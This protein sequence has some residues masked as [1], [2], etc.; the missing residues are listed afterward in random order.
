MTAQND[1]TPFANADGANALTVSAY[2]G[3][4]AIVAQGVQSGYARSDVA[5]TVWR[6]TSVMAAM[7]GEFIKDAG[8]DALDDGDLETLE[9]NFIA[10]LRHTLL[11]EE[12]ALMHFGLDSGGINH[13]VLSSVTPAVAALADGMAFLFIPNNSCTG[14]TD[15]KVG[16]LSAVAMKRDDGT[17]AIGKGDIVAGRLT[18]V[19]VYDGIARLVCQVPDNAMWHQGA[20]TGGSSTAMTTTLSP[21]VGVLAP[22]LKMRVPITTANGD[23]PTLDFGFGAK[24][25]V[26]NTTGVA[27]TGGEMPGSVAYEADLQWD[28]TSLRLLNPL[29]SGTPAYT[30]A[31][32]TNPGTA[33]I[34]PAPPIGGQRKVPL[35]SGAWGDIPTM[36]G[37]SSVAAGKGGAVPPPAIGDQNRFLR[38]DGSWVGILGNPWGTEVGAVVYIVGVYLEDNLATAPLVGKQMTTAQLKAGMLIPDC[39]VQTFLMSNSTANFTPGGFGVAGS[40]DSRYAALTGNWV[41]VAHWTSG[42]QQSN[43]YN[44][45]QRYITMAMMRYE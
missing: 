31:D 43:P 39:A 36:V 10:A 38:G 18:M 13:V 42:V 44:G 9:A 12:S 22:H 33:G 20:A 30:G 3:L 24:P 23:A 34:V 5:N 40:S 4:T 16:S 25:I 14:A 1:F 45:T 11:S 21:P 17:T 7:L 15:F 37:A 19:V 41:C 35:G 29:S 26:V 32:N 2:R 27:L 8:Y 28:G 6:Q